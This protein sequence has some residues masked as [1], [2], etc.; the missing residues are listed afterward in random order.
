MD[1]CDTV[2]GICAHTPVVCDDLDACTTDSCE[3]T[4]GKCLHAKK[5]CDDGAPCTQD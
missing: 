1:T 2:S 5:D 3:A 4:T